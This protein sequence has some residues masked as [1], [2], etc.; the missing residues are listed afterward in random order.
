MLRLLPAETQLS[1]ARRQAQEDEAELDERR[2]LAERSEREL[3]DLRSTT[4]NRKR[5]LAQQLVRAETELALRRKELAESCQELETTTARYE[6][7]QQDLRQQLLE[8]EKELVDV[9]VE[10]SQLDDLLRRRKVEHPREVLAIKAQIRAAEEETDQ[11][12][13]SADKTRHSLKGLQDKSLI[14]SA[15]DA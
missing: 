15:R 3:K 2:G 7:L 14:D 13:V 5:Q 1:Q 8:R 10:G 9:Q 11:L 12:H 4:D 6:H